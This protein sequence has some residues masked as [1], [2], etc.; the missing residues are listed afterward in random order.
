MTDTALFKI[1]D[2]VMA[3]LW[4]KVIER[5]L[6]LSNPPKNLLLLVAE[7]DNDTRFDKVFLN[8]LRIKIGRVFAAPQNEKST[9]P[10]Y[11]KAINDLRENISSMLNQDSKLIEEFLKPVEREEPTVGDK[12]SWC[13]NYQAEVAEEVT[14]AKHLHKASLLYS[15]TD[16]QYIESDLTIKP[17]VNYFIDSVCQYIAT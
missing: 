8:T 10:F 2:L 5:V 17:V 16:Q 9:K 6:P 15:R 1:N 4:C 11:V 7:D 3:P 13:L 12:Q 14:L